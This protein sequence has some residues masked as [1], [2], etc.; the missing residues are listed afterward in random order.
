[1][2]VGGSYFDNS[3]GTAVGLVFELEDSVIVALPGPPRELQAMVQDEMIPFLSKRFGTRL[4]G[5]SLTVRLIGLGQS[6]IDQTLKD[7]V[8]LDD[9]IT[10]SSQFAGGRVDFTFSMP[11]DTPSDREILEKLKHRI[12]EH[13]GPNIYGFDDATLE[14]H[15]I[16]LL[17]ERGQTLALAEIAGGGTLTTAL[18]VS[19]DAELVLT[20]A[21]VAPTHQRMLQLL[22]GNNDS[23]P[24]DLSVG[25][26]SEVTA[27]TAD[28]D[29]SIVV[30]PPQQDSPGRTY[31]RIAVRP[32]TGDTHTQSISL[33]GD[34]DSS[35]QRLSTQLL[36]L[37]RRQLQK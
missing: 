8:P 25:K 15:V 1:M 37:L 11:N 22:Y 13:L 23:Q 32:P 10:V 2:P 35:R 33:S 16:G 34:A 19:A 7:H 6:G 21:Y 24:R 12:T 31:A 26:L 30:G 36:D 3:N 5:C 4:P 29:W 27:K 18:S 28:A 20:G 14:Q 17:K 9:R